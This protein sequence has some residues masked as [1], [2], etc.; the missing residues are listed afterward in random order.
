MS[1]PETKN[2]EIPEEV[3]KKWQKVVDIMAEVLDVPAGL[4]MR[5]EPP[6]IEVFRSSSGDENPYDVGHREHLAGL[7][8][9]EVIKTKDK[10]LVP[11]ARKS[12][13]WKDNPDISLGMFSY[14]GFPLSWPDGDIFG[15]I[16]VLDSEENRYNG[17]KNYE[18]LIKHFKDLVESHLELLHKQRELEEQIEKRKESEKRVEFLNSLFRHD[19][20]NKVQTTQGFIELTKDLDIDSEAKS[21]LNKA[22]NSIESILDLIKK[23][24]TLTKIEKEEVGEVR[25]LGI[26]KNVVKEN[27]VKA[28]HKDIS[29]DLNLDTNKGLKN[30]ECQVYG[31]SLLEALFFNLIENAINHAECGKILIRFKIEDDSCI[32]SVEDDGKG[33]PD[34]DKVKIFERGYKKGESAGSGLGLYLAKE[35]AESYNGSIDIKDSDLGGARFDVKLKR[36]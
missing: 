14:L 25:V 6:Y 30:K 11:D 17:D 33:I 10:L 27:E 23:M 9:E 15:T 13:K 19:V 28:E 36:A 2:T 22:G 34:E 1:Y 16:C 3:V 12:E 21:F 5:A 7:Y 20:L 8:C 32:I 4:V 31:G 24:R 29:I 26:I 35:I 18:E